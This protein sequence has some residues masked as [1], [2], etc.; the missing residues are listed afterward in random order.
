MDLEYKKA[1]RCCTKK[2]EKKIAKPQ[3]DISITENHLHLCWTPNKS[4]AKQ[5]KL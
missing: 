2:E 5:S 1:G 3:N 4:H